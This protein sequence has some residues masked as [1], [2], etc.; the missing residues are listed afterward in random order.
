MRFAACGTLLAGLAFGTATL[1]STFSAANCPSGK[2]KAAFK[3]TERM[4]DCHE[5]A[6]SLGIAVEPLCL[7]KASEKF[8]IDFAHAE[9]KPPCFATGD[10]GAIEARI[11]TLASGLAT[12]LRPNQTASR[13]AG[14]KLNASGTKAAK[15]LACHQQAIRRATRVSTECLD[16]ATLRFDQRFAEAEDR[17]DCLTTGDAAAT[18]STIDTFVGDMVAALRPQTPSKC[19][20]AKLKAAGQAG[21]VAIDCHGNAADAGGPVDASCLQDAATDFAANVADA[22]ELPDCLTLGDAAAVQALVDD[23]VDAVAGQLRP[24]L[25]SSQCASMKLQRTGEAYERRLRCLASSVDNGLPLS[26]D[27]VANA[28]VRVTVALPDIEANGFDCLTTGDATAILATID[29]GV[30]SVTGALLP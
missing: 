20:A 19:T 7:A 3:K 13:C 9:S 25:T 8:A 17:S 29:A 18:E 14:K 21:A 6:A 2:V 30:G 24:A 22:E 27:C 28:N 11:D 12:S 23:L 4:L 16:K 1:A 10:A 5:K 15:H 26:P